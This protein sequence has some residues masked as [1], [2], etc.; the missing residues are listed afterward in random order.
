MAL[1]TELVPNGYQHAR[2]LGSVTAG[3]GY[4]QVAGAGANQLLKVA[5][6]FSPAVFDLPGFEDQTYITSQL[7]DGN[8]TAMSLDAQQFEYDSTTKQAVLRFRV[9]VAALPAAISL[10]VQA[11]H[12]PSR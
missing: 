5:L 1:T 4:G 10:N 9:D 6:P 3:A 11:E 12:T 8:I 7:L 2:S